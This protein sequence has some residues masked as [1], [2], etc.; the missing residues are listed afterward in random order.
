VE[1][2]VTWKDLVQ[3][4]WVLAAQVAGLVGAILYLALTFLYDRFFLPLSIEPDDVGLTRLV[5]LTRAGLGVIA[6]A[7]VGAVLAGVLI[8]YQT[9][10]WLLASRIDKATV[11]AF[12][13]DQ[14]ALAAA[15]VRLE[16]WRAWRIAR[17]LARFVPGLAY[18][19]LLGKAS[20]EPP[21]TRRGALLLTSTGLLAALLITFAISLH[22]VD[23]AANTA[24]SGG[25]VEPLTFL[26]IRTLDI[27]STPCSV[28]WLGEP[29]ATP[30]LLSATD[31]HC[32][33]GANGNTYFRIRNATVQVPSAN[34]ATT[35]GDRS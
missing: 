31:I 27:S 11:R 12:K 15:Q 32:L 17:V 10:L 30:P 35:V 9:A 21:V 22:K 20:E 14:A 34:V 6:I 3:R 23:S 2:A 25:A 1:G 24:A 19:P 4:S 29:S 33:G 16:S 13:G 26:G 28:T 5:V 18:L 7:G 8:A